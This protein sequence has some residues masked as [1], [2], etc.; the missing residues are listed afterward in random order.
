MAG[1]VF[2]GKDASP[3]AVQIKTGV[4]TQPESLVLENN[5]AAN[6]QV[7]VPPTAWHLFASTDPSFEMQGPGWSLDGGFPA[8]YQVTREK[9]AA[10][11]F[12]FHGARV[13]CA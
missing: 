12:K 9:D 6:P 11:V 4:H 2:V 3:D 1:N 7:P 10:I 5:R 13:R 8:Q